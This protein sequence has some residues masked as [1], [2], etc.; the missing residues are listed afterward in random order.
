M[1]PS[2][3]AY[4]FVYPDRCWH[5]PD[6]NNPDECLKCG[7]AFQDEKGEPYNCDK[8]NPDLT[9]WANFGP[10]LRD[11]M[12]SK[13]WKS[14]LIYQ[15][16]MKGFLHNEGDEYAWLFSDPTHFLTL[17]NEW[18][19]LPETQDEFGWVECPDYPNSCY[20]DKVNG[21]KFCISGMYV[22]CNGEGKIKAPWLRAKEEE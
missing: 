1:N 15:A 2:K 10:W 12:R 4:L 8:D 3:I 22:R 18:L 16:F 5:E 14:F 21:S 6:P 11:F 13:G 17:V 9:Q 7:C 19:S 20:T